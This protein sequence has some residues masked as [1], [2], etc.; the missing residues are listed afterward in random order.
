VACEVALE[1]AHR[2]DAALALGCLAYKIGTG[3]GVDPATGDRDD[4]Q[5]AVELP[6]AA[7]M[8]AVAVASPRGCR[9][10]SD[11]RHPGEMGI[12]GE[13]LGASSLPNQD[14]L[15]GDLRLKLGVEDDEI[16]AQPID[17]P[18][19][20]GNQDLPV[21]AAAGSRRLGTFRMTSTSYPSRR[22]WSDRLRFR[23]SRGGSTR[24][25]SSQ[26]TD[27]N[28]LPPPCAAT[29]VSRERSMC[30]WRQDRAYRV[31][32]PDGLREAKT[33]AP[34]PHLTPSGLPQHPPDSN[35]KTIGA[36]GFEP[37]TSPTRTA[38]ATRLRH[39]PTQVPVSHTAIVPA[40]CPRGWPT[41][42][43]SSTAC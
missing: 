1:A 17:Q 25:I 23:C 20:L 10:R 28:S 35:S 31:A 27:P 18:R 36:P 29:S 16:P 33:P 24:P 8:E 13:A 15:R 43:R 14:R 4:V 3:R 21:I 12:A 2:L 38:R 41:S 19:A 32:H 39:A 40:R 11:A 30:G 42:C 22:R 5:R 9:N 7:A 6:V 34:E 26:R 37:G